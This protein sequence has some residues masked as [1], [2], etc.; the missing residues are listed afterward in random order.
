MVGTTTLTPRDRYTYT[1]T[2]SITRKEE[3][4]KYARGIQVKWTVDEQTSIVQMKLSSMTIVGNEIN[5]RGITNKTIRINTDS[6]QSLLLLTNHKITSST[7]FECHK[8]LMKSVSNNR[9][10][11]CWLPVHSYCRD[12]S[13]ADRLDN[14]AA[15]LEILCPGCPKTLS[16]STTRHNQGIRENFE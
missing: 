12:N 5:R 16:V 4:T 8:S 13:E 14:T 3:A 11:L 15:R 6:R 7:L 2:A 1:I 9:L 10:S